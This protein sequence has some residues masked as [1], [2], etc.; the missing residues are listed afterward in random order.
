MDVPARIEA[1][2]VSGDLRED[3]ATRPVITPARRPFQSENTGRIYLCPLSAV[4]NRVDAQ[5]LT[6]YYGKCD[7]R[8]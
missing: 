4:L 5:P 7:T 6:D 3:A 2:G 1:A 8:V